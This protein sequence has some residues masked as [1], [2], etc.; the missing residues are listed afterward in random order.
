MQLEVCI[1]TLQ[2]AE[3]ANQYECNRIEVCSALDLGG[4]TP[5]YGL[6]LSCAKLKSIES[7]I[8]IR[9]R[10]GNFIYSSQE[11]ILMKEDIKIAAKAG[12]KGVVFGCLTDAKKVDFETCELLLYFAQGY[13]LQTTFHRAI[14]FTK[15]YIQAFQ[16]ITKMGFNRILT[17][18]QKATA[19]D[20]INN[21]Q[22]LSNQNNGQIELM[23]GSGINAKN[24]LLFQE[25]GLNAIH[26]SIRQKG[27]I[28][29]NYS[30]GS[31]YQPDEIKLQQIIQKV[32]K[33]EKGNE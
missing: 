10:P 13:Q 22:S 3:L 5:S 6:M 32:R 1:E 4:L 24:V 8:L 20:G 7:H 18:G 23:A 16:T 19:V 27:H 15:D 26:F 14:D 9:P 21:I 31:H 30:M 11:I 25:I 17:S 29:P 12:V 28:L 33:S 2:E